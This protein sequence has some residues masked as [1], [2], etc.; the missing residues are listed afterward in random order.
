[1]DMFMLRLQLQI[2]PALIS[3]RRYV[4]GTPLDESE[5][6]LLQQRH[7]FPRDRLAK[8][9]A[10]KPI[11]WVRHPPTSEIASNGP[12]RIDDRFPNFCDPQSHSR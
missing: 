11:L 7:A 8:F 2:P 10:L 4:N 12:P 6:Q 5:Q 9:I 1:M 3:L